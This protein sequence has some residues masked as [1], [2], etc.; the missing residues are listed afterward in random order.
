M[1][2]S[3]RTTT[4]NYK[5]VSLKCVDNTAYS[6]RTTWCGGGR[7][8]DSCAS[9]TQTVKLTTAWLRSTSRDF[10][11][12]ARQRHLKI[13]SPKSADVSWLRTNEMFNPCKHIGIN[14][15]HYKEYLL[16]LY[17]L[18]HA[19]NKKHKSNISLRKGTHD[20]Y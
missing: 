16:A 7:W 6:S 2:L 17:C 13:R 18:P 1:R 9:F 10:T 5:T 15:L 19:K 11:S 3:G 8:R 20:I 14:G 12:P 4:R